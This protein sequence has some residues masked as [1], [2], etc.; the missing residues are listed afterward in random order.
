M[1]YVDFKEVSS[2]TTGTSTKY[3]SQDILDIM[4]IF[5]GKTVGTRRPKIINPW[6]WQSSQDITEIAEPA[7]PDAGNQRLFIDSTSHQLTIKNSSGVKTS[8]ANYNQV[9]SL[10]Q[11]AN[12]TT[13]AAR[14]F[15]LNGS[16]L[17]ANATESL[18]QAT[19]PFTIKIKRVLA[20][21]AVHSAT[22]NAMTIALR[23]DG[24]DVG[25]QLSIAN[26]STTEAD[27][28]AVDITIAS[29]SKVNWRITT[30]GTITT[31]TFAHILAIGVVY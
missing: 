24:A 22:S 10:S 7:S 16:F 25:T 8:L 6:L 9:F 31:L 4:K 30:A 26:N 28:G 20:K 14:Y 17:A 19:I 27:S 23:D 5:N 18:V 12:Y 2:P 11:H 21:C 13:A 1:S 3:G 15:P 29:G